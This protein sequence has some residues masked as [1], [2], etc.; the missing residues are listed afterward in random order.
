M[1][2]VVLLVDVGGTFEFDVVGPF[3]HEGEALNWA[4]TNWPP[5]ADKR[6]VADFCDPQDAAEQIAEYKAEGGAV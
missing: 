5:S 4:Q 2:T 6:F 1:G 3:R